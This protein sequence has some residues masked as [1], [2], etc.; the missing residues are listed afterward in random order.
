MAV[1]ILPM[2]FFYFGIA[3][4]MSYG[5]TSKAVITVCALP[6]MLLACLRGHTGT[7]T[8]AYYTVFTG[9]NSGPVDYGG[10]PLFGM[11]AEAIWAVVPDPRVVTNVISLTIAG[12]TIWAISRARYGALFGGLVLVPAMF[13]E[14]T[15]NVL[16]FGVASS[17]FLI[18]SAV[19]F[20]E[21]PIRYM[22]LGTLAT[23]MHFSSALLFILFIGRDAARASDLGN[24]V[25]ARGRGRSLTDARLYGSEIRSLRGHGRAERHLGTAV[26][27][28]SIVFDR[29]HYPL[30]RGLRHADFGDCALHR[31]RI[32]NLCDDA[33]H[34][35]RHPLPTDSL[36]FAY[37]RFV[38]AVY[39][40]AKACCPAARDVAFG[41]RS[42]RLH[43]TAS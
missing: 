12:L 25:G 19:P 40:R 16:R 5:G 21:K 4:C 10:E 20:K 30:A 41:D 23:G 22:L 6:I 3:L 14:L 9:L 8:A 32:R 34:V 28:A 42:H 26:P 36:L 7:D 27:F 31:A 11:Y 1:Y 13:Y 38:A 39:A 2:L 33:S 35:R 43:R 24:I 17:I 18:A 15:F 29:C 37:R